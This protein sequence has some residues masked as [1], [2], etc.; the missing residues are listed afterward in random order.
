MPDHHVIVNADFYKTG[1]VAALKFSYAS[2][3]NIWSLYSLVLPSRRSKGTAS[4]T[5]QHSFC[6]KA[7]LL[8][9]FGADLCAS[10]SNKYVNS[11]GIVLILDKNIT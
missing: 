1:T 9:D 6:G 8:A 10:L 3:E 5:V 4:E 11:S 2:G 7:A